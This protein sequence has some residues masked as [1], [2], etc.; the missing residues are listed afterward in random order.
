MS[1]ITCYARL[2][3]SQL[4]EMNQSPETFH[5]IFQTT[6]PGVEVIDLDKAAGVIAWLLSPCKRAEQVEFAAL[7]DEELN[8][9]A[10]QAAD[11][12]FI[13]PL[14]DFAMCIE[15]R[16]PNKIVHLDFGYGPACE[17]SADDVKRFAAAL[18]GV[19]ENVL[20]RELNFELMDSQELPVE[21]WQEKGEETFTQYILPLFEKLKGFYQ[22]A[23]N[24]GQSVLVWNS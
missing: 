9:E 21:Y 14:D 15:G 11:P 24:S 17:F 12:Q 20:R 18:D 7:I 1:I 4:Q 5:N 3:D 16:G 22:A 13:P 23:A 6:L 10:Q 19:N 2:S 8:G